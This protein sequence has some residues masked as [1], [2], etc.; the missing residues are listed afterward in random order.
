MNDFQKLML[1]GRHYQVS[2]RQVIQSSD[3]RPVVTTVKSGY[4]KRYQ[5]LNDGSIGIQIIYGPGSVFPLTLVF[6]TLF[7]QH[8]YHGQEVFYYEAMIDSEIYSIDYMTLADEVRRNPQIYANLLEESG[9]HLDSC[10]Q[11]LENATL[12]SAYNQLAHQL[13]YFAQKF[14]KPHIDGIIID[15]PLTHQDL[16][17]VLNVTRET[18]S[19]AMTQLKKNGFIKSIKGKVVVANPKKLLDESYS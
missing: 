19:M 6:K 7:N 9:K 13:A 12:R 5:I 4:I 15:V 14:G 3:H 11:R 1:T 16:A 10:V 2:K 17:S 8:I 18:V